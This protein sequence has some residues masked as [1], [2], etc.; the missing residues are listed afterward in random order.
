MLIRN[1]GLFWHRNDVFWGRQK[2][3][4][5]LMGRATG[6]KTS[7]PVDF[8]EQR[9]LYALYDENYRLIYFGQAGK[10]SSQKLFDR[11]K[12][13]TNDRN[14]DRWSRFSWF[15]T[16]KVKMDGEL[17]KEGAT[18]Q[19][20]MKIALD[21]MEAIV[22]AVA[23][24]PNNRQG[25][26]FGSKVHQFNQYRDED[27]LGPEQEGMIKEIYKHILLYTPGTELT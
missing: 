22:L 11:L 25:G 13:H 4:G 6:A 1:Y 7:D 17:S 14:A 16:Q 10:G 27:V 20:D 24:P 15:G 18:Q 2:K 8:R 3:A 9:G 23:E 5:H 12:D 21:H 26:Q 19:G